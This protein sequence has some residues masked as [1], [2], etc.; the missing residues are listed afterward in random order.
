[1]PYILFAYFVFQWMHT[2]KNDVTVLRFHTNPVQTFLMRNE[3]Y[4]NLILIANLMQTDMTENKQH[5][6]MLETC[7]DCRFAYYI[8]IYIY[9]LEK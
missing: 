5:F 1:M 4:E 7:Y 3:S 6:F 9:I 8:Y 2:K